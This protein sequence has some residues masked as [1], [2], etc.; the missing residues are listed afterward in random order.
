VVESRTSPALAAAA[1]RE[2]IRELFTVA[3]IR[4]KS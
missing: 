4:G 3:V 2:L 1:S